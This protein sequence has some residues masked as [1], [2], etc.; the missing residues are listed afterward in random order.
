MR[1]FPLGRSPLAIED[2][3]QC[4]VCPKLGQ[5][6]VV[7]KGPSHAD[8]MVIGHYP[9]PEDAGSGIP[10]SGT[11]GDLLEALLDE[12]HLDMDR[13]YLTNMVKCPVTDRNVTAAE[14]STC[15][16]QWLQH[17]V[18]TIDPKVVLLLGKET[19]DAIIPGAEAFRHGLVIK[20]TERAYLATYHPSYWLRCESI[21][22]FVRLGPKLQELLEEAAGIK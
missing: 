1:S 13:V 2:L 4:T 9:G 7:A 14:S 5:H 8:L 10:F 17:E 16:E 6:H 20:T 3:R 11:A 21:E 18:E 15:I 12:V 19:H 22:P